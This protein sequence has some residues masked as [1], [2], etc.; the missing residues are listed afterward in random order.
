MNIQFIYANV[1]QLHYSSLSSQS[2][3]FYNGNIK[4][5]FTCTYVNTYTDWT[6]EFCPYSLIAQN[7]TVQKVTSIKKAHNP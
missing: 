3:L 5:V 4:Y 1:R 6:V 7:S 2:N